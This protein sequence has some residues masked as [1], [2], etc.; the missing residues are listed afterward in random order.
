[1]L[2]ELSFV[3]AQECN[4]SREKP[5]NRS[6]TS[7]MPRCSSFPKRN[8]KRESKKSKPCR[9]RPPR[10]RPVNLPSL[11]PLGRTVLHAG[12]P[13]LL[14]KRPLVSCFDRPP[15]FLNQRP[16]LPCLVRDIRTPPTHL[17][18]V[19]VHYFLHVRINLSRIVSIGRL[20]FFWHP[21]SPLRAHERGRD[22]TKHKLSALGHQLP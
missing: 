6:R 20:L 22:V 10:S 1:L 16:L 13:Q 2:L 18:S 17:P 14:A 7:C 12:A 8:N 15:R 21:V 19:V 3:G 5:P 11:L 9:S 4:Q